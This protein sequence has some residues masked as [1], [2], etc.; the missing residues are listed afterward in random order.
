MKRMIAWILTAC[1][2]TAALSACA[3]GTPVG[4]SG[5]SDPTGTTLSPE[6]TDPAEATIPEEEM[7][8]AEILQAYFHR[9]VKENPDGDTQKLANFLLLHRFFDAMQ[10]TVITQS[11]PEDGELTLPGLKEGFF[12]SGYDSVTRIRPFDFSVPFVGYLFALENGENAEEFCGLLTE[13]ADLSFL[14]D[15]EGMKCAAES[16]GKLVFFVLCSEEIRTEAEP[17]RE[18]SAL[19]IMKLLNI[20]ADLSMSVNKI[21]LTADEGVYYTGVKYSSL[22]EADAAVCEPMIGY[23]FSAVLVKVKEA[24]DAETVAEEMRNGLN[25]GKWICV[26]A[27]NVLVTT[28][29]EYV[30]GIMSKKEEGERVAE[31]FH[32]LFA[33]KES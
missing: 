6:T 7:T 22:V 32:G 30:F 26:R 19:Y 24:K 10:T 2:F 14:K 15:V 17:G 18:Q 13:N 1:L 25:P 3:D 33:G 21:D 5:A 9:I 23:G 16:E 4:T 12:L 28:D 11:R 20:A 27:E 29:G 31:V 8:A